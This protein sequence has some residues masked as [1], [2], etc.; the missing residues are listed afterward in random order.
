MED[1]YTTKIIRVGNS[2]AV[3]IPR[4]I[5]KANNWQKGDHI[6][7]TFA[8]LECL[9][10]KRLTDTDIKRLKDVEYII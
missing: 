10:L 8:G 4:H 2:K 5:L 3:V 1:I 9:I 6:I 7:F